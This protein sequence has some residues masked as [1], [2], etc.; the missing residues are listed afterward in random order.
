MTTEFKLQLQSRIDTLIAKIKKRD[1]E[2]ERIAPLYG[3]Q[4]KFVVQRVD[5]P[6]KID[7]ATIRTYEKALK[8]DQKLE[9]LF[10]QEQEIQKVKDI[11]DDEKQKAVLA[12]IATSD[13]AKAAKVVVHTQPKFK[14]YFASKSDEL[15][16]QDATDKYFKFEIKPWMRDKLEHM[17]QNEG[18]IVSNYSG[19]N[20]FMG[21]K[22]GVVPNGNFRSRMLEF[23]D[24]AHYIVEYNHDKS[25]NRYKQPEKP[26]HNNHKTKG[27]NGGG[28]NKR[29]QYK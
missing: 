29:R 24:G 14:Y 4:S 5:E 20:W 17:Y 8:D 11:E 27:S 22:K 21:K 15:K 6:N 2:K 1:I 16:M 19:T 18:Y 12:K 13:A 7:T 3:T 23:V 25:I 9:E 28:N 10:L 26:Q